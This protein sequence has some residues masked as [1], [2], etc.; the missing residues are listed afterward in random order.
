M[1]NMLKQ[2]MCSSC[3]ST[4]ASKDV[5]MKA[6]DKNKFQESLRKW[7]SIWTNNAYRRNIFV[8]IRKIKELITKNLNK[9]K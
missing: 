4:Q 7:E 3:I 6:V 8:F 1:L 5:T 9:I 2:L